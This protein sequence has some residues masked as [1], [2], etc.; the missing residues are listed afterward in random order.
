M[1][2]VYVFSLAF[3][4]SYFINVVTLGNFFLCLLDHTSVFYTIHMGSSR[5]C[6]KDTQNSCTSTNINN[7]LALTCF[8]NTLLINIHSNFV[9]Q[10]LFV[11]FF[12][13]VRSEIQI[14]VINSRLYSKSSTFFPFHLLFIILVAARFA[15]T[16]KIHDIS[17]FA[18]SF[19][20]N[21]FSLILQ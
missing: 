1:A 5:F 20:C 7:Y 14:I 21:C 18:L 6:S 2:K 9:V 17:K 12:S 10:H 16:R 4:K 19:L 11:Y 3:N 8:V 15:V 13:F